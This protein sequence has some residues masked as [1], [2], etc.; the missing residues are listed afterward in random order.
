M[1]PLQRLPP[2]ERMEWGRYDV[3]GMR[4][5]YGG[6]TLQ[7]AY[8][9]ALAWARPKL[10]DSLS[11]LFPDSDA[12]S[13]FALLDTVEED[14]LEAGMMLPG[15]LATSWRTDRREYKLRLPNSG[16]FVDVQ[17]SRSIGAISEALGSVLADLGVDTLTQADLTG[18]NRH[19]TTAIGEWVHAQ[20]LDDGS[21][22]HGILFGSK[23]RLD[24][25]FWAIWLRKVDAGLGVSAEPTKADSGTYIDKPEHNMPLNEI[26][27]LFKLTIY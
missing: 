9:E 25:K 13:E 6:S 11:E 23:Q 5:I 8:A 21:E 1:N 24:L 19:V 2:A 12:G 18:G 7:A 26:A 3:P 4:T 10:G 22:P 20:T 15:K 27:S 16:W 14:W 17:D